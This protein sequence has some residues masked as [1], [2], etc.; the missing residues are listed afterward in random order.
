[1][2]KFIH[3]TFIKK[4]ACIWDLFMLECVLKTTKVNLRIYE[5]TPFHTMNLHSFRTPRFINLLLECEQP[6]WEEFRGGKRGK[7]L[8]QI[9]VKTCP[10]CSVHSW[11]AC[12]Q[13]VAKLDGRP[14][15]RTECKWLLKYLVCKK[16][17]E[18]THDLFLFM[19]WMQLFLLVLI[20]WIK[21]YFYY[22]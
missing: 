18:F 15:I 20:T 19:F 21:K 3:N 5:Q 2:P 1:M 17:C 6:K 12:L 7:G 22:A 4:S 16:I 9:Y 11:T 13:Y 14:W 8:L 10:L